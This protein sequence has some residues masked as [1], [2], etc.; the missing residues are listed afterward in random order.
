VTSETP[1]S[2]G[3]PF[4][5]NVAAT[6][7]G[8]AVAQ[9]GQLALLIPISRVFDPE[10]LGLFGAFAAVVIVAAA[11]STAR[12]EM[13]IPTSRSARERRALV[14][15]CG[16]MATAVGIVAAAS[17]PGW[18]PDALRAWAGTPWIVLLWL[19]MLA[20]DD[21]LRVALQREG[22][23]NIPAVALVVRSIGGLAI[24]LLLGLLQEATPA[25]LLVGAA[26][27][28]AAGMLLQAA[29]VAR[30]GGF[31]VVSWRELRLV[32]RRNR[33]CPTM[34]LP[35]HAALVVATQGP[36]YAIEAIVG[37]AAAGS[38]LMAQRILFQPVQFVSGALAQAFFPEAARRYRAAGECWSL[39]RKALLLLAAC[40]VPVLLLATPAG[41]ALV[42]WVLGAKWAEAGAFAQILAIA[43][44]IRLL[45]APLSSIR[46]VAGRYGFDLIWKASLMASVMIASTI[47]AMAG[48]GLGAVIGLAI[49]L[50]ILHSASLAF[51]IRLARGVGAAR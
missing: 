13:A 10:S 18:A 21:V 34:L 48:G 38:F 16:V 1:R 4:R 50:S 23:F 2:G 5:R 37:P 27:G 12:F 43:A 15:L 26:V 29:A 39:Y 42:D 11:C 8:L 3:S 7:V 19:P 44:A 51:A 24:A 47:G 35:G 20:L 46:L 33:Q 36:V 41:P 22:C 40:A 32:A 30:R 49:S 25:A 6:S 14:V 17:S 28:T 45:D 31:R 9:G